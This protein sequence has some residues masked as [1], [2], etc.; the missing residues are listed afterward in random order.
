MTFQDI[1]A[2]LPTA[3]VFDHIEITVADGLGHSARKTINAPGGAITFHHGDGP[4]PGIVLNGSVTNVTYDVRAKVFTD[5]AQDGLL[6]RY[7]LRFGPEIE[8]MDLTS[9]L[10]YADSTTTLSP[11]DNSFVAAGVQFP[12]TMGF[13]DITALPTGHTFVKLDIS[14]EDD[15]G[16]AFSKSITAAGGAVTFNQGDGGLTLDGSAPNRTYQVSARL[17]TNLSQNG[18]LFTYGI[19]YA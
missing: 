7:A 14:V 11:L 13:T 3:H 16:G 6:F 4:S 12:T 18:V 17:F 8:L 19:S 2:A 1:I 10:S 5:S 9:V 15:L